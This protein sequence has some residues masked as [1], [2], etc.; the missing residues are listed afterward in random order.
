MDT[1]QRTLDS[2]IAAAIEDAVA[3]AL[4]GKTFENMIQDKVDETLR[5]ALDDACRWGKVRDALKSKLEQMLVPAIEGYSL[6]TCNVKVEMLLDELIR[7]SAIEERRQIL[8]NARLLTSS[9]GVPDTIDADG[10]FDA[11]SEFVADEYDC[12]GRS[13]E[14]GQYPTISIAMRFEHEPKMLSSSLFEH[15]TLVFEPTDEDDPNDSNTELTR[16]IRVSRYYRDSYWTIDELRDLSIADLRH[17]DT[18]M[19]RMATMA[20]WRTHLELDGLTELDAEVE[21]NT[22]P[23]L[24]YV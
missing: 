13:V 7:E 10:L 3:K 9:E 16:R 5:S 18:F 1:E 6:A 2:D 21:P 4:S 15:A 23:D 17:L 19:V 22:E 24:E 20:Q 12:A 8:K 14:E 11:Y